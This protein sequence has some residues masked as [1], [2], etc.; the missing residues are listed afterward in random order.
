MGAP[1][2]MPALKESTNLTA[3]MNIV[4]E[5]RTGYALSA[6]RKAANVNRAARKE[7]MRWVLYVVVAIDWQ[8]MTLPLADMRDPSLQRE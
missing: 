2:K 8:L 1:A 7:R 5:K 4:M 3:A 6:R